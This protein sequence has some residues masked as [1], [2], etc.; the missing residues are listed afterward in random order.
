MVVATEQAA[1]KHPSFRMHAVIDA[2]VLAGGSA[3]FIRMVAVIE[4]SVLA[5]AAP[6]PIH[7]SGAFDQGHAGREE[8]SPRRPLNGGREGRLMW[9]LTGRVWQTAIQVQRPL[10]AASAPAASAGTQTSEA[11]TTAPC[12]SLKLVQHH[13]TVRFGLHG[14]YR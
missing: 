13:S 4:A 2:S 1:L 9:R 6:S 7:M 5:G 8:P 14:I 3:V 11:R 12:N 10:I